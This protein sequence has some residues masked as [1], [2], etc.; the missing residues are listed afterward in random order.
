MRRE[1][2]II[3]AAA[4]LVG[5][6]LG[7]GLPRTT[8]A[9]WTSWSCQWAVSGHPVS[10]GTLSGRGCASWWTGSGL[11]WQVWADTY[12]PYSNTIYTYVAGYDRCGSNSFR[13]QMWGNQT[14]YNTTYGTS[15]GGYVGPYQDCT[16]GH[17]YRGNTSHWRKRYSGSGWEG[18]TGVVYW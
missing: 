9:A 12:V 2:A 4:I 6:V 5:A 14:V 10:G 17:D 7:V 1:W 16:G 18:K 15:G 3:V 13:L 8:E 11:W